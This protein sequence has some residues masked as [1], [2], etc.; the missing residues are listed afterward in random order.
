MKGVSKL[1]LSVY[2]FQCVATLVWTGLSVPSNTTWKDSVPWVNFQSWYANWCTHLV[3]IVSAW[4]LLKQD[5]QD[6]SEGCKCQ[7][8]Q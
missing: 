7:E 6:K 2:L 5:K 4:V 1:V 8:S 3:G